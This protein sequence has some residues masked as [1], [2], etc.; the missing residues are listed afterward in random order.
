ML[1]RSGTRLSVGKAKSDM[2]WLSAVRQ[3]K[4]Y[5]KYNQK[6]LLGEFKSFV[7]I[8]IYYTLS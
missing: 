8:R 2:L 6:D 4:L 3:W 7:R 1:K 5:E